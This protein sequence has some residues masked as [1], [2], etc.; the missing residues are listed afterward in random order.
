MTTGDEV[1]EIAVDNGI[2]NTEPLVAKA[3]VVGVATSLLVALGAFGLVTEEQRT[4]IIEQ[5]GNVTYGL[6]VIAPFVISIGTALWG[7]L[8]TFAPRTAAR[9]AIANLRQPPLSE[10]TLLS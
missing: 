4:V 10:P 8:S 1:R 2:M 3:A 5:V 6:F 7:R 9:I